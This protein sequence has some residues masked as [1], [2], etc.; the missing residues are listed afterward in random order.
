MLAGS[1]NI[2]TARFWWNTAAISAGLMPGRRLA[3]GSRGSARR[4]SAA[5]PIS[6]RA[7]TRSPSM[8]ADRP[9]IWP[10]NENPAMR[11]F[12]SLANSW[13]RPATTTSAMLAAPTAWAAW[14]NRRDRECRRPIARSAWKAREY[15]GSNGSRS[16]T[17]RGTAAAAHRRPRRATPWSPR[18]TGSSPCGRCAQSRRRRRRDRRPPPVEGFRSACSAC[19]FSDRA[20]WK[21]IGCGVAV[22]GAA[23]LA[24]TDAGV[25]PR[26]RMAGIC[27]SLVALDRIGGR[28]NFSPLQLLPSGEYIR[29]RGDRAGIQNQSLCP[30]R[31][32]C[33]DR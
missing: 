33:A 8:A 29:S 5:T 18:R 27:A 30:L 28:S 12:A 16:R 4:P 20:R 1:A 15:C 21:G 31:A 10:P 11:S 24:R 26:A 19:A 7:H 25:S 13:S 2:S 22:V 23:N 6:V 14:P 9:A 17:R 3:N 32:P